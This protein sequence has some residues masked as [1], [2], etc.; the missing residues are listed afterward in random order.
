MDQYKRHRRV[1]RTTFTKSAKELED[2]LSAAEGKA[3]LISV[4][5]GI[6]KQKYD[7]LRRIDSEIYQSLLESDGSEAE[8]LAEMDGIIQK[9]WQHTRA[10]TILKVLFACPTLK[11]TVGNSLT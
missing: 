9:L 5:L 11:F 3:R 6:L 7:D 4:S 10:V 2:F 8:L 1:L